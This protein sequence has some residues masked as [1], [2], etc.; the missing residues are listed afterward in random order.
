MSQAF[1]CECIP[2]L[3]RQLEKSAVYQHVD[4]EKSPEKTQWY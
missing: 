3:N 4:K 1:K 2:D